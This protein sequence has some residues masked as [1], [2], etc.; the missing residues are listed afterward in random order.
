[1]RAEFRRIA[2]VEFRRLVQLGV[3]LTRGVG[4]DG[5]NPL[6]PSAT[7]GEQVLEVRRMRAVNR[8]IRRIPVLSPST[9]SIADL[10]DSPVG[11]RPSVSTVNEI[12]T[13][14]SA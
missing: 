1:M 7:I 6:D 4:A 14:I 9:A 11:S 13:G 5:S 12:T 8:V 2:D 3:T 10:S